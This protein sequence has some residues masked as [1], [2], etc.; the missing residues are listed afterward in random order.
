MTSVRCNNATL[1][2]GLREGENELHLASLP[3][4]GVCI[5]RGCGLISSD[6]PFV[7]AQRRPNGNVVGPDWIRQSLHLVQNFWTCLHN[8]KAGRPGKHKQAHILQF[9]N[10][11]R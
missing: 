8:S 10:K 7:F 1:L 2:A 5:V 3:I 11:S 4:C 9:S 6:G